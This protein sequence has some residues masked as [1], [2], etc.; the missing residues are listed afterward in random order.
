MARRQSAA[1]RLASHISTKET[2]QSEPIPGDQGTRQVE[3]SA[4]GFSFVVSLWDRLMRFLIIGTDKGSYYATEKKLTKENAECVLECAK[5]DFPRTLRTVI[6]VSDQGRAPKND[7]ALLAL[8]LLCT[9]PAPQSTMAFAELDKV[10]R[11]GTHLFQFIEMLSHLRGRGRAFRRGFQNWYLMKD[12]KA[13]AFQV[14]KYQQRG[15][16]SHKDILRLVKPKTDDPELNGVFA[17]ITGKDWSKMPA[18]TAR[19]YLEVVQT[20]K[21]ADTEIQI[22]NLINEYNLPREV[23]PTEWLKKPAVWEALL[24]RM[25]PGALVR[26]LGKL[27][28]IGLT[29]PMSTASGT[30]CAKLSDSEWLRRA[31]LHPLSVLVALGIYRGGHGLKG[32]MSWMAD[33]AIID[34]LDGAFYDCFAGVRP[35]GKR[36]LLAI[37]ISDSMTWSNIAGTML[38]PR[39]AAA[40]MAMVS[41]R[42]EAQTH[43]CA[44]SAAGWTTDVTSQRFKSWPCGIQV[45]TALTKKSRLDHA[46]ES[47]GNM[48]AGDTDCALPMLYATAQK[49][50]V[51][52]FVVYTDNELWAGSVHPVQALRQ[53]REK[54]GIPAKLIVVG[55]VSNEFSIAD[56]N[57][58]GMMDVVGFDTASPTIMADFARD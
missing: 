26:N 37:D 27:A 44:F 8:A 41:V 25:P 14:T 33:P 48:S 1:S 36:H 51:D 10:A 32:S 54:M 53:Y 12:A 17:Y 35:T 42:S 30:V 4:G 13:V 45:A 5:E 23:I 11:I 34:A 2:P 58:S 6:E 39:E 38:R 52:T 40:A 19:E 28:N 24:E 20:A 3:N 15:D 43:V 16:W 22:V 31:R 7:P 18:G 55:M 47:L 57:D 9:L 46:V 29:T 50:P 49:I 21:K 56:P